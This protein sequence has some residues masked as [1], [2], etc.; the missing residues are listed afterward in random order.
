MQDNIPKN[1]KNTSSPYKRSVFDLYTAWRSIPVFIRKEEYS[2]ILED[3]KLDEQL[4]TDLIKINNQT[5]FAEKYH[6]ENSTLTNWNKL[7]K[8]RDILGDTNKWAKK[9]T[10]NVLFALYKNAINTGNPASIKLWLQ[11]V[12]GWTE[13]ENTVA[14]CVQGVAKI[15]FN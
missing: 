5:E 10:K 15:N 9:L 1:T 4:L 8:K 13:K 12:H 11:V 3:L 14:T 2:E 7:I 6:V